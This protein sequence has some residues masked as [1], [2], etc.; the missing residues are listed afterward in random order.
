M[1]A[2]MGGGMGMAPPPPNF[3]NILMDAAMKQA[4]SQQQAPMAPP[5]AA[6]LPVMPEPPMPVPA[7]P[8]PMP[9][10]PMA[11]QAMQPQA[12][13]ARGKWGRPLYSQRP[14]GFGAAGA[15]QPVGTAVPPMGGVSG[16]GS[17]WGNTRPRAQQNLEQY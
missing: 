16:L 14:Q 2:G 9:A 12:A 13:M 6:Q 5:M 11:G 8:M 17:G 3:N 1:G 4:M 15:T 7:A 10:P